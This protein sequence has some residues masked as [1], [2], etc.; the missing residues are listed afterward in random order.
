M[1]DFTQ[2]KK[3]KFTVKLHDGFIALLPM[4]SKAIFDKMMAMESIENSDEIYDLI[5]TIINQNQKKKYSAEKINAM[6]DFEDA[7]EFIKEYIGFV[8]DRTSDPN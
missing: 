4:P 8:T 1:L 5:K 3:K 7:V 2:A 6:F